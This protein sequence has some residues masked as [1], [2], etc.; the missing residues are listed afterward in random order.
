MSDG[1]GY[2]GTP[3]RTPN[4]VVRVTFNSLERG[5]L[6]RYLSPGEVIDL[7]ADRVEVEALARGS[8]DDGD[9]S[10]GGGER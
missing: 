2:P 4:S 7:P 6:T 1:E 3:E 8:A 9:E 10:G 5:T